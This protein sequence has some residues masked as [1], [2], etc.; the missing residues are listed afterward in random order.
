MMNA[1]KGPFGRVCPFM[2]TSKH[3]KYGEKPRIVT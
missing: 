1:I 2:R 3:R